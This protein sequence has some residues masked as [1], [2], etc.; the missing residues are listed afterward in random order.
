MSDD[1]S[2]GSEKDRNL[3]TVREL[4]GPSAPKDTVPDVVGVYVPPR[5]LPEA[6]QHRTM[7]LKSVRL[8]DYSRRALTE[9][10]L[11]SPP[12]SPVSLAAT[13]RKGSPLWLIPA[14]VVVLGIGAW[15]LFREELL[16]ATVESSEPEPVPPVRITTDVSNPAPTASAAAPVVAPPMVVAEPQPKSTSE[17]KVEEKASAPL[18]EKSQRP[19]ETEKKRKDPWLE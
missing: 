1:R 13:E 16:P 12:R 11:V 2:D 7:D 17:P 6:Q 19:R 3:P 4:K 15:L 9:R 18:P 14:L 10:R 5:P 8:E